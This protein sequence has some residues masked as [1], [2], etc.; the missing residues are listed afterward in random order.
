MKAL[1]FAAALLPLASVG[2]Q[3]ATP[4]QPS[5]FDKAINQPGIGWEVYGPNQRA[6]QVPAAELPGGQAVRV[7]VAKAG[8]N[9]WDAGASYPAIK[10]V[11]AG[12][13]LLVMVF[14]RA[15]DAAAGTTVPVPIGAGG[16][17]AP[18]TPVA[19]ETVQ[20]GS[21]WKRYYASGVSAQAFAAGKAR[22]SLQ[23]AGAKQVIEMGPAFLLNLGQN[24][25]PA[26]LPKN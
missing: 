5:I 17:E 22:I 13:T 11:A 15:P 3:T 18:Y 23:L 25:N 14:L 16:A 24:V 9:P 7:Q 21:G 2:A 20:V 12:D 26:T 4:A 19:A 10:P 6:K 8:A 1:V